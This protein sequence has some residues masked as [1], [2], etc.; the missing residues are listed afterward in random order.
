MLRT[1]D[2]R[3]V[4]NEAAHAGVNG[5]RKRG[6][7]GIGNLRLVGNVTAWG[8]AFVSRLSSGEFQVHRRK[9]FD[10]VDGK[11]KDDMKIEFTKMHGAGNDFLIIDDRA[12]AFPDQDATLVT[13][14]AARRLGIG[15]EGLLVLRP[16][17]AASGFDYQMVFLNPDGSRAA[18]C[19]N[20]S[21]CVA[22]FAFDLGIS[23]RH[24]RILT[25]AGPITADIL[26]ASPG[27]GSVRIHATPPAGRSGIV[28]IALPGKRKAACFTVNTGVP[29]AVVFVPDAAAVDVLGDG[30][31]IRNAPAFAPEGTNVDFVEVLAAD[32]AQMRTYERGVEDESGACGTGALAAG[33]ALAEARG[34]T[35]PVSILV[36]SGD[37]LQI[38]G[39]MDAN[40]LCTEMTLAGPAQK[41]F[42][43][44][45]DTAWLED[46]N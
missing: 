26:D 21:R 28:E 11:Q 13:R 31:T 34:A 3:I 19:G 32:R 12:K 22:L 1:R 18:M 38:D 44:V 41:V 39:K 20:A 6:V 24:Q 27:R 7:N 42:E 4:L 33:I 46:Q 29:H 43:G 23:G 36:S 5:K 15:S 40:G 17:D 10:I 8:N 14:L 37:V 2:R 9:A 30:R 25:D 45:V 35:L 16:V